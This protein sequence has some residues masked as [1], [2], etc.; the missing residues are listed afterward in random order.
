MVSI[1]LCLSVKERGLYLW[2]GWHQ[3]LRKQQ[4]NTALLLPLSGHGL[5]SREKGRRAEKREAQEDQQVSV[6]FSANLTSGRHL[7]RE[8]FSP[9]Q[10]LV[11][12]LTQAIGT[13]S[14]AWVW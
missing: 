2:G 12:A 11:H 13:E 4:T 5:K 7:E 10:P 3:K 6:S 9:A 8:L 1:N 14:P